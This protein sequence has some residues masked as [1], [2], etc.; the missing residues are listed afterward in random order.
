MRMDFRV[1]PRI[2]FRSAS[3]KLVR[4]DDNGKNDIFLRDR[5]ATRKKNRIKRISVDS[6]GAEGIWASD[7]A[8]ISPNGRWVVF[9]TRSALVAGDTDEGTDIYRRGP[10]N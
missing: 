8:S 7:R 4:G 10:L 3:D 6:S 1:S 9:E 5:K 2:T